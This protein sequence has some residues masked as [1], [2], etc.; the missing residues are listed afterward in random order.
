MKTMM[1]MLMVVISVIFIN[2]KSTQSH[3]FK[4]TLSSG[5]TKNHK[6]DDSKQKSFFFFKN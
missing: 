2:S 1:M 3:L 5:H 4:E 6:S